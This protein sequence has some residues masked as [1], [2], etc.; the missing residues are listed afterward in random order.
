MGIRV[1]GNSVMYKFVTDFARLYEENRICF[2]VAFIGF[3]LFIY[4]VAIPSIKRFRKP[5]PLNSLKQAI[6]RLCFLSEK[7]VYSTP[8]YGVREAILKNLALLPIMNEQNVLLIADTL[9]IGIGI[10]GATI[11]WFCASIGQLWYSKT[12]MFIISMF[13]PYY[14]LMLC[15]E[16]RRYKLNKNIPQMIDEFRSAFIK[17]NKIRPALRECG[18]HIDRALGRLLIDVADSSIMAEK[19]KKVQN[20]FNNVW[21]NIFA[22]SVMQYKDSGGELVEQLYKLSCTMGRSMGIEKKRNRRLIMYEVFIILIAVISIPTVIWINNAVACSS[23]FE[24]DIPEI[25]TTISKII[26]SSI[27]SLVVIRVLRVF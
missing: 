22:T 16:I 3:L 12:L 20:S 10:A 8:L 11:F 15:F 18:M 21:F 23:I 1:W 4:G 2:T 13:V 6:L 14:I 27:A 26:M 17:C 5:N 19:L 9:L 24:V 25:N 7:L